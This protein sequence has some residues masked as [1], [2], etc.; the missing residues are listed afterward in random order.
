[1]TDRYRD[2]V[3]GFA[4]IVLAGGRGRRLGGPE[5]PE[6]IIAGRPM[7]LRVLDAVAGASPRVL[8]GPA[9]AGLPSDVVLTRENPPGGGPVAAAAAGMARLGSTADHVALLAADLPLL[10]TDSIETLRVALRAA[11]ADGA[12]YVDGSGRLQLLCGVWR[13]PPLRG[14]LDRLAAG[15]GATLTGAS[16]RALTTDLAV[17][18][19]AWAGRGLPPWFDC[20]T[21]DDLRRAEEWAD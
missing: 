20:D 19:V 17:T 16:M 10:S 3:T 5:K 13:T 15:P 6:R 9:T 14:A 11:S 1:M 2:L 7:V 12:C 18:R 8:V 4:A 21:D